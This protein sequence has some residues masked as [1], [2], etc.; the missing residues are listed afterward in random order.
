MTNKKRDPPVTRSEFLK[1]SES[2][3]K[4]FDSIRKEIGKLAS[5]EALNKLDDKLDKAVNRLAGEIVKTQADLKKVEERIET[6]ISTEIGKVLN[7]IDV[8][9]QKAENYDRKALFHGK[10]IEEHEERITHLEKTLL[11]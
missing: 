9:T 5:K 2:V 8:F 10:R 3:H 11:K 4:E 7:A 1:E 6:K